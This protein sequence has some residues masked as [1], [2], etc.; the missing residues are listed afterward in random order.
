MLV[1]VVAGCALAL[2][3]GCEKKPT[4]G[5][6]ATSTEGA[7][8]GGTQEAPAST[9]SGGGVL[10]PAAV[11]N[12][13]TIVGVVKITGNVPAPRPVAMASK[14]ECLAVHEDKPPLMDSLIVGADNGLQ[15]SFVYISK[16]LEKY[17]FDVPK[18]PAVLDQKG[19]MYTPHVFPV[20]VNQDLKIMNSDSFS[21]NVNVKT[22]R[23]FNKAQASQGDVEYKKKWFKKPGVPTKFACDIHSWMSA[24]ACVVSNPY[25]VLTGDDGKFEIPGLP[26]GKYTLTVWHEA[27]PKL[28]APSPKKVTV[29]LKAG[30]TK[31]VDFTYTMP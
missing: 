25:Y 14:P 24:Y 9:A 4:G 28:K 27:Y 3:A 21:H 16:G 11:E 13:A 22:N 10:D 31:T 20:R 12:P 26:A 29:E 15:D 19:C 7:K 8:S 5:D 30:E 2:G 1:V 17:K 18:E 6:S 23:P